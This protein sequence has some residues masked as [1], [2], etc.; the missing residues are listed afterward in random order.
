M[1]L[2]ARLALTAGL[3]L[4]AP[5]LAQERDPLCATLERALFAAE[6]ASIPFA[7]LAGRDGRLA[8]L[9]GFKQCR[10]VRSSKDASL[11]CVT[12]PPGGASEATDADAE[13]LA[14]RAEVCMAPRG[15]VLSATDPEAGKLAFQM[16]KERGGSAVGAIFNF[17]TEVADL[18]DGHRAYVGMIVLAP[19]RPS[20][21]PPAARPASRAPAPPASRAARGSG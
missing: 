18:G 7:P 3:A 4:A 11:N 1:S 16:R 17:E 15:Y 12:P 2:F 20:V 6:G 19:F 21:A 8:A 14:R 13:A 9:D 5:A 10:L